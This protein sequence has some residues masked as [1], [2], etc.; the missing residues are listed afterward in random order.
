MKEGGT[1]LSLQVLTEW[2]CGWQAVQVACL[3]L[4][5]CALFEM[6]NTQ[7][8]VFPRLGQC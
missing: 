1:N 3:E 6:S 2:R 8:R 4:L 7:A 5:Q